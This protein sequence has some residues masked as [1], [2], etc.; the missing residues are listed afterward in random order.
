MVPEIIQNLK[1]EDIS[2]VLAEATEM[3]LNLAF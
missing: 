1:F 2:I 3:E